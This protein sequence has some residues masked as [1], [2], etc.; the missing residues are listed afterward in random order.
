MFRGTAQDEQVREQV[1]DVDGFE[2]AGHPNGQAFMGELIDDIEQP[3]FAPVMGAL[4][5]K[6]VGP[7]MVGTFR[8]Q[9]DA[10]ASTSSLVAITSIR[11]ARASS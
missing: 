10:L 6:V 5:D 4:L 1:D 11:A 7:D 2:P 3:Q 8:P 9:P